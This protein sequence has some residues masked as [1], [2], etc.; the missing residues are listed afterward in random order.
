[1]NWDSIWSALRVILIIFEVVLIFNLLIIVH[2]LGHFLAA[3]WRKLHIDKFGIWFGKPIWKKTIQGVEYSLGCIPAGGFVLLP[4]MAPMEAVEGK[5]DMPRQDL[6]PISSLDKIIVAFAGPFFSFLL[7]LAFAGV[8]WAVGRPTSEPEA[9]TTIGYV[10]PESP[11]EKAGFQV[12]DQIL[13][14]DSHPV[15]RFSGMTNSVLW[16]VVRSEGETIPFKIRRGDNILTINSGFVRPPTSGWERQSL[17]DVGLIPKVTPIVAKLDPNSP[18]AKA[19]L[20]VNDEVVAV[21][22]EPIYHLQHLMEWAQAHPNRPL[23]VTVNRAGKTFEINLELAQPT[24]ETVT[25]NSPAEVA[26]VK[27]GDILV[28]LDNRPIFDPTELNKQ[29]LS[30]PTEPVTLTVRR[31]SALVN[32]R[33]LAAKPDNENTPILGIVFNTEIAGISWD[34]DGKMEVVHLSPVEQISAAVKTLTNTISALLSPQSD[35]KLQHMSGPIMIMRTYYMLFEKNFGWQL[36]LW[37]SVVFNINLAIIN[38]LPIPVLDGG[39]IVLAIVEAIRRRPI[40][41]RVLEVLQGGCALLL[42]G[43]MLYVSFY[44]AVDLPWNRKIHFSTP[45]KPAPPEITPAINQ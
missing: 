7:A 9:T 3:R 14:V 4:Q 45:A 28:E 15:S 38:L 16:Y 24:I 27:K 20:R 5:S 17:R 19:G 32:I 10:I 1:M 21:G 30:K 18:A 42:I 40:N 26:G 25:K 33:I 22:G 35:I 36:A 13:D 12:G 2:E 34:R 6:P 29:I 44:D 43:F 39:H 23:P 37:F 8:V 11:G 31:G 41:I